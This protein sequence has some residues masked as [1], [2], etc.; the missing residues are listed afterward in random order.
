MSAAFKVQAPDAAGAVLQMRL[1]T[2]VPGR[3]RADGWLRLFA[4]DSLRELS[5]S[6]SSSRSLLSCFNKVVLPER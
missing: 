5:S 2:A 1:E 3:S 6:S 4:A